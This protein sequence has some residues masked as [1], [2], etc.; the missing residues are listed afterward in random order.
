MLKLA[1]EI[2]TG[3][4]MEPFLTS[5]WNAAAF[6]ARGARSLRAR[7][8]HGAYDLGF[9]S[10]GKAAVR[11][12]WWA[13]TAC[14]RSRPSCRICRLKCSCAMNS[15]GAQGA[16]SGA[17]W[18]TDRDRIDLL[19]YWPGLALCVTRLSRLGLHCDTGH[20]C[21]CVR[22]RVRRICR[23]TTHVPRRGTRRSMELNSVA[24]RNLASLAARPGLLGQTPIC[25]FRSKQ[26][27]WFE[28]LKLSS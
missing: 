23:E 26:L 4:P 15:F 22:R 25:P 21:R 27:R 16:A 2:L 5:T 18:I 28:W 20:A 1:G 6:G 3:E 11:T 10:N 17:L 14:W 19:I 13:S 7:R 24:G 8:G 12:P 9:I